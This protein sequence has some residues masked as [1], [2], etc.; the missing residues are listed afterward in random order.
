MRRPI[1]LA[2]FSITAPWTQWVS[3]GAGIWYADLNGVY[4]LVDPELSEGVS[5]KAFESVVSLVSY[6]GEEMLGVGSLTE[7]LVRPSFTWDRDTR[8][9]YARLPYFN[10]PDDSMTIGM[11][12]YEG[13]ELYDALD[14]RVY[15][16]HLKDVPPLSQE[17][18]RLFFKR[19]ATP[20]WPMTL[21]NSGRTYD[22]MPEWGVYNQRVQYLL[23]Y[24]GD[25]IE[26]FVPVK[27]GRIRD[28]AFRGAEVVVNVQDLRARLRARAPSRTMTVDEYPDLRPGDSGRAKPLAFGAVY[29][30]EPTCL[31]PESA[32]G[33]YEF[34]L[35]DGYYAPIKAVDEVRVGGAAVTPD[36]VDLAAGTITLTAAQVMDGSSLR[37]VSVDFRG[38]APG[39]TLISNPLDV[40][41]SLMEWFSGIEYGEEEFNTTQWDRE[42]LG[43][44]AVG[45]Y[46]GEATEVLS[47]VGLMMESTRGGLVVDPDGRYSWRTPNYETRPR[48]NVS[49]WDWLDDPE[50]VYDTSEVLAF[51]RVGYAKR[52]ARREY[53]YVEDRSLEASVSR[54]FGTMDSESFE[55]ALTAEADATGLASEV[56]F[57]SGGPAVVI[58][59]RV[60]M[61]FAGMAT[62]DNVQ[63]AV[64]RYVAGSWSAWLGTLRGEL[65]RV[66]VDAL[67]GTVEVSVRVIDGIPEYVAPGGAAAIYGLAVAGAPAY[68]EV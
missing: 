38:Y 5:T 34:M 20:S 39:G 28:F 19:V 17:K 1:V 24:G 63:V 23:G 27:S 58:S 10:P 7:L 43:K 45:L 29:D 31:N 60:G 2:Q 25:P 26:D 36:S 48:W 9:V 68:G 6:R 42:L 15:L 52:E 51:A 62:G 4:P 44:P 50:V 67:S 55:T 53:A 30:V 21:D 3:Y 14:G 64:N 13:S 18:D 16:P 47:L 57:L 56:M 59:G 65:L 61:A 46:V 41:T 8:T 35:A 37:D 22:S 40:V 32:T 54:T 33:P 49:D 66:A 11:A 12:F